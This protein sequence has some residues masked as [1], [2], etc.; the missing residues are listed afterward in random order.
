MR[1]LATKHF[2]ADAFVSSVFSVDN[3]ACDLFS[4]DNKACHSFAVMVQ[5]LES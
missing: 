4:V 3:K 1:V 5:L 2:G